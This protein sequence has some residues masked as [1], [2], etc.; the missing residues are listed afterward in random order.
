MKANKAKL[1]SLLRGM[2]QHTASL[3]NLPHDTVVALVGNMKE[4]DATLQK[5]DANIKQVPGFDKYVEK[6][7]FEHKYFC[8]KYNIKNGQIPQQ[9]MRE[10]Q[11]A[12]D[13][14]AKKMPEISKAIKAVEEKEHEIKI[15]K[16]TNLAGVPPIVVLNL[17]DL[18]N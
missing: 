4:I 9:F 14:L 6:Q 7:E 10:W 8:E 15:E 2:M 1:E 13:A 12:L 18:F 5:I 3:Q 11:Q 16:I 17:P